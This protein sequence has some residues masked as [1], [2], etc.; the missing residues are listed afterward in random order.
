MLETIRWERFQVTSGLISLLEY[1][2]HS[3]I[4]LHLNCSLYNGNVAL[5]IMLA[6]FI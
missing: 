6:Y 4:V 3:E 5:F 1:I 2:Y